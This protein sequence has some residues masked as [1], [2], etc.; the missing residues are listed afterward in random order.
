[1]ATVAEIQERLSLYMAAEKAVLE[2]SQ[3]YQI[4]KRRVTRANLA[5]IRAEISNLEARL[6]AA[7]NNGLFGH[8]ITV[9]GGRR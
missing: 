4:G 6:A 2:G 1:M 9:F 5:E 7:K 3:E 8:S